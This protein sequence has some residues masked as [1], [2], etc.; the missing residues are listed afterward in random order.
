MRMEFLP[1][2][3]P[4][5]PLI[6]L[7]DF[8]SDEIRQLHAAVLS[9]ATGSLSIGVHELRFVRPLGDCRPRLKTGQWDQGIMRASESNDFVCSLTNGTWENVAGLVVHSEHHSNT[10]PCMSCKPRRL[11]THPWRLSVGIPQLLRPVIPPLRPG[12][13]CGPQSVGT[14]AVSA[15]MEGEA[16]AEA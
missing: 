7:F 2:G 11:E 5:T 16:D 12:F 10:L 15:G 6:R 1:D 14:V 8:T 4:V 13:P 9:L 3:S